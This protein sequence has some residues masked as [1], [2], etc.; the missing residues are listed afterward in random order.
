MSEQAAG[1]D[2]PEVWYD[3]DGIYPEPSPVEAFV[4]VPGGSRREVVNRLFEAVVKAAA[5]DDPTGHLPN[6]GYSDERPKCGC[7]EFGR[8]LHDAITGVVTP[9]AQPTAN[10]DESGAS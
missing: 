7:A 1:S 3:H 6:C 10:P 9:P 8:R 4:M 2:Q 5:P